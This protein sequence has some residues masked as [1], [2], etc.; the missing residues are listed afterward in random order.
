V[1][2]QVYVGPPDVYGRE[3]VLRVQLRRYS[4]DKTSV[5]VHE[6]AYETEGYT[7]AMMQNL[8]NTA[9]LMATRR[10]ATVIEHED[11]MKALLFQTQGSAERWPSPEL[12]ECARLLYCFNRN[13]DSNSFKLDKSHPCTVRMNLALSL[14][15]IHTC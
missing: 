10:D 2:A 9:A 1:R 8:C 7:G 6:I 15:D 5:R 14:V 13:Q 4:W 12:A 11:F 3:D